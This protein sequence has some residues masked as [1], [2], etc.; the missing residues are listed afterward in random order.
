MHATAWRNMVYK[1]LSHIRLEGK[2]LD[3]GGSRK[4]G[5]HEII[6]GDPDIEVG[7]IE[8]KYEFDKHINAEHPFPV[9]DAAYSAVLCIN[10]MEHV[11]NYKNVLSESHRILKKNGTLV[12]AVPF[13][14]QIHPCPHDYWRFSGETLKKILLEAGFKDVQVKALG[15]G[16]FTAVSQL[17]HNPLRFNFLRTIL[18]WKMT[19]LDWLIR[20]L[21]FNTYNNAEYFPLGY[22]VTA[23]K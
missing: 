12:V 13:L 19:F 20:V 7:N 21:K 11:Y 17:L 22:F 16:P 2:V 9:E 8:G 4:S 23:R 1:E 18:S 6:Q 3:L 5:Y 14:I 15:K 10:V